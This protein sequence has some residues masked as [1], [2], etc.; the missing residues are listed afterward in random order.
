MEKKELI[1]HAGGRAY[2]QYRQDISKNN[3]GGIKG[4]KLKPKV[5]VH[6]ENTEDP[7]RFFVRLFKLYQSKCSST[8][9]KD[10]FYLKQLKK[11]TENCLVP[12]DIAALITL[13]HVFVSLLKLKGIRRITLRVSRLQHVCSKQVSTSNS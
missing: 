6:H 7:S 11:P 10:A 5:V 3:P 9:P 2:L 1:E 12:L 4:R 8:Q 13:F